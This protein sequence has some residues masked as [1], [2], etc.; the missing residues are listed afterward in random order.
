[1]L[2]A[3]RTLGLDHPETAR[4]YVRHG[5]ILA[6]G[7]MPSV[8]AGM[9][10]PHPPPPPPTL[11]ERLAVV[12]VRCPQYVLGIYCR[13]DGSLSLGLRYVA[14]SRF[15]FGLLTGTWD[16]PQIVNLEVR[17]VR[18]RGAGG[19]GPSAAGRVYC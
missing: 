13:T 17:P 19:G 15:L 1:M 16:H 11:R 6:G 4:L 8:A 9:L 12:C 2:I 14:R 18:S 10:T 5:L 7:H 3:E